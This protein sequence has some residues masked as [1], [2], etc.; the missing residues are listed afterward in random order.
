MQ[1]FYNARQNFGSEK[2]QNNTTYLN[3]QA[4][5]GQ[6]RKD[7]SHKN[8]DDVS[9]ENNPSRNFSHNKSYK[10][11]QNQGGNRMARFPQ[12]QRRAPNTD[13]LDSRSVNYQERVNQQRQP[14]YFQRSKSRN[15]NPA[16]QWQYSEINPRQ[17]AHQIV[18]FYFIC[19]LYINLFTSYTLNLYC[20]EEIGK[21]KFSEKL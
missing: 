2:P 15:K 5:G 20:K 8:L 7:H 10:S 11:S 3:P 12:H 13:G 16:Q 1:P 19:C 21:S 4:M 17:P 14:L 6:F 9:M 18:D